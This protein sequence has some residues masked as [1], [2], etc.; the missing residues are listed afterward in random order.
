M[1]LLRLKCPVCHSSDVQYHSPYTPKN[2]GGRV[3]D[4]CATCPVYWHWF[5]F[6]G[7]FLLFEIITYAIWRWKT[8]RTDSRLSR[9]PKATAGTSWVGKWARRKWCTIP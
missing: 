5:S 2:H 6:M 7:I 4:Q 1:A 3:I 9:T 8:S